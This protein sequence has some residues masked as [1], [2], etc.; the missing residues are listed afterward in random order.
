MDSL[1]GQPQLRRDLKGRGRQL[2]ASLPQEFWEALR[3]A[4]QA[5]G[6]T[7]S[8]L[9]V[10]AEGRIPWELAV[11]DPPLDAS[12]PEFLSTQTVMGRWVLGNA[13]LP[14]PHEHETDAM[15]VVTGDYEDL[16]RWETLQAA[17][18][19]RDHLQA[20]YDAEPVE[21]TYPDV[22]AV[23]S[24]DPAPSV[25]HLA[26]H[27]KYEPGPS[28]EGLV[29][30]DKQWLTPNVVMAEKLAGRSFVFLNACQVGSGSDVLHQYS[31]MAAAFLAVG[32]SGVIA[33]LWSVKDDIARDIATGF[34]AATMTEGLSVGEAIR[35]E[36]VAFGDESVEAPTSATFMA[37]Q[38]FG[39]PT[40]Q[41]TAS[42]RGT[43]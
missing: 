4:A 11:V 13:P 43:T 10:S 39:H 27:G 33:P 14:P 20:T 24:R 9:L 28:H 41:L 1:E 26:V 2:A 32:A 16:A 18:E 30:T 21:A 15:V 31:G 17:F 12:A 22:T 5:A 29:L 40:L 25:L 38:Y 42:E 35:R 19:E 34:Y 7:P 3:A 8:L 36:R 37:Y 23:L 6:G